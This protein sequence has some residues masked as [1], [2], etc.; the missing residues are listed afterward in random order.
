MKSSSGEVIVDFCFRRAGRIILAASAL[1][2]VPAF[3]T[4]P[5]AKAQEQAGTKNWKDREEYDA[6][7]KVQQ[8]TDPKVR[9]DALKAWEDKYPQ[10]EFVAMR[11]QYYLDTLS[12][13]AATDPTQRPV[14]LSKAQDALKVD[15]KNANALYLI[16]LWGPI[17]GG[18]NP[19]PELQSQVDTAAHGF[20]AGADD[21]FAA[22][23]KPPNMKDEDWN[24]AKI[25]RVALAHNALAWDAAS[26]KD[27]ATAENEYKE[28]LTVNPEQGT[29]SALY[30]KL[31]F[32]E[33]KY[34]EALYQYAR[35]AQYTGPGPAQSATGRQQ[36]LDF[37]NKL[38]KNFHGSDDGKDQLLAQAKTSPLPPAGYTV[39][40]IEAKMAAEADAMNAR[41]KAD[42]AFALWYSVKTNLIADNGPSFFA[43]SVKDTDIPGGANGVKDFTGTILTVEP[44]DK[45]TRVTLGIEDPTKADAT[46]LFSEPV[47]AAALTKIKVGEKIDFSGVAD[48]FT[49]DPY[50]LTFKDPEVVG[51]QLAAPPKKPAARRHK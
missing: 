27:Y 45:P 38:Y 18:A 40:G 47:P 35:T 2:F 39:T 37:F 42:P 20:I 46:L 6:F 48:N 36:A 16:S 12:R 29:T 1:V 24:K 23:N 51:V 11:Y 10:S 8:A 41:I 9:L 14:L 50:M 49:K 43:S 26:K 17:V 30:A 25:S 4:V 34:P 15:P 5:I 33:K 7:Q 28:S 3:V 21:A 19:S 31:L 13:L 44:A 32:D 22:A